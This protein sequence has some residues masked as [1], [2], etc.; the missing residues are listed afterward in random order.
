MVL[1]LQVD[2]HFGHIPAFPGKH[3]VRRYLVGSPQLLHMVPACIIW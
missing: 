1:D 2:R 3:L